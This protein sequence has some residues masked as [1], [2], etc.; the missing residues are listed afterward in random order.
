MILKK[1]K[2]AEDPYLELLDL[3]NTPRDQ[4]IG[5][6]AQPLMGRR[7]KTQLPT[8]EAFLKPEIVKKR[9]GDGRSERM[10]D[11]LEALL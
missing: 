7:T 11:A 8:S 5:S 2:E 3:R 9:S 10:Q 4:N 6:P 1:W